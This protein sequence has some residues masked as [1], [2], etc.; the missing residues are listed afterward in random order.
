M[1]FQSIF[2][3]W[4]NVLTKPGEEVFAA[5]REK[6]SATLST[7][8]LWIIA[9]SVISAILGLL[10]AQ[11]FSSAMGGM[12]QLV[13]ML[14]ADLQG[15]LGPISETGS[16]GG[17][18]S[19]LSLIIIG[20]I[21][22]LIG[23]GIF[24]VI[25]TVLGGRGQYGRYAYLIATFGAPLTI[26]S[27]V[28]GFVPGVGA[29]FGVIVAIYQLVLSFHATKVEYG[30]SQGRAIVVV[31]APVLL[32]VVLVVCLLVVGLGFLMASFGGGS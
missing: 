5:E 16:S 31:V 25:A 21:G 4:V 8:L 9:A 6:S 27:S 20:P 7:A 11:I 28:L 24:H 18:G 12:S 14:P 15:E 1:D 13:E 10:Q 29:C 19:S 17:I 22:F 26:V 23:V 30:L 2:Q 32:F 3:T